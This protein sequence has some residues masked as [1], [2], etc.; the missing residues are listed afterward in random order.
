MIYSPFG[1]VSNPQFKIVGARA[2]QRSRPQ[3]G[4]DVHLRRDVVGS[5]PGLGAA[6][7][8]FP[9]SNAASAY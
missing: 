1:E 6:S 5:T 2:S 4:P 9:M 7:P 3:L 8:N